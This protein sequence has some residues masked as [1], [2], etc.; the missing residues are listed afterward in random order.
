MLWWNERNILKIKWLSFNI[1]YSIFTLVQWWYIVEAHEAVS[2]LCF[3]FLS[4]LS[5]MFNSL[6][7]YGLQHTSFPVLHHIPEISQTHVHWVSDAIQPS[8][9]LL[10]PSPPPYS[11]RVFSFLFFFLVL[12]IYCY[13]PLS[14]HP[15]A[16]VLRHVT[17]WTRA[18]QVPLSIDFSRQEYWSGLP[19][20]SPVLGFPGGS[21]GKAS[22][23]NAG[24]PGLIPRSER[25]PE[26]GNGNPL[27][28]SCLE[29]FMDS[30][31]W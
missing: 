7:P 2:I 16:C 8:H 20:S 21:D 5:V 22:T 28:Y 13:K 15:H 3:L 17:P 31:V 30:G 18:C 11:I 6:R 29:K 4:S 12:S 1:L 9:P 19:F 27:R 23:C 14:P 26:E 25:S 24:Y 10:S